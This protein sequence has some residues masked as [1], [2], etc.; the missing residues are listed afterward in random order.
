MARDAEVQGATEASS[1]T[2]PNCKR[3]RRSPKPVCGLIYSSYRYKR[4]GQPRTLTFI[5]LN[6]L[7][8]EPNSTPDQNSRQRLRA[9][10]P[11]ALNPPSRKLVFT[12]ARARK[13]WLSPILMPLLLLQI[14]PDRLISR[15]PLQYPFAPLVGS[16]P[17]AW[18]KSD[19]AVKLQISLQARKTNH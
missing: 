1:A 2:K 13:G 10:A 12:Q 16:T 7:I 4:P 14:F 15:P 18:N 11:P 9:F 5:M 19:Y 17:F 8:C 6:Y 3:Y